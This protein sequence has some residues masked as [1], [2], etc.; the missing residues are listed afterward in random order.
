MKLLQIKN[1]IAHFFPKHI[2]FLMIKAVF[3]PVDMIDGLLGRRKA[4]IP[5]RGEIFTGYTNFEQSGNSFVDHAV[6][7]CQV[8]A[9]H[10]ILDVG[11]GVGRIAVPFTKILNENGRYEG[12]DIFPGGINWCTREITSRYPNF[13]FTLADIYNKE[14]NPK[15]RAEASNYKFPYHEGLF[16]LVMLN[17]VFTHMLPNDIQNYFSEIARVLKK[18]GKCW[19]SFF[20]LND[21]TAESVRLKKSS[22]DFRHDFGVYRTISENVKEEAVAYDESYIRGLYEKNGMKICE[23][24]E[25]G[26][27]SSHGAGQDM[28]LAVK[29]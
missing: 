28:I 15:G 25:Y 17:S 18:G 26:S 7:K 5:P 12:F 20:L 10:K 27:W 16:D 19:I 6:K 14:Y 8:A 1:K 23:P 13:R 9:D 22:F 21:R 3:F 11:C 4:M 2:R 24:I 29:I